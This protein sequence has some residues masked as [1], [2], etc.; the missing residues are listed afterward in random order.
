MTAEPVTRALPVVRRTA[1]V[2]E[3]QPAV[4]AVPVAAVVVRRPAPLL[5]TSLLLLG[6]L[7]LGF[8]LHLAVVGAVVHA[9]AQGLGY[10]ELREDLA[11]ATAPVGPTEPGRPVALLEVPG[12]SLREVVREGTTA[13]VLQSGPGHRRDSVLPGQ[14]GTSVLFGR[15]AAFG[16]PFRGLAD[17]RPGQQVAV[18][19]G[20]GRAVFEVTG[21]RRAGDP[22][23][24]PLAAGEGRLTLVTADGTPFAP[25]GVLRVD[26][27]LIGTAF[28]GA[29]PA[30]ALEE[31]ERALQGDPGAL[32]PLLLL[33]QGLLLAACGVAWARTRWGARQAWVA[34]VPVLLALGLGTAHAASALLPN[35]L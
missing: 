13:T 16:A 5:A 27:R 31:R 26:A 33:A 11:N 9:R 20:L 21:L 4:P 19:S 29:A 18:T 35:L 7:L 14:A 22:A 6:V 8:V 32:V 15:Q 30:V 10:A 17:L 2:R 3:E 28:P 1:V 23:P 25:S 24:A 34:G 12:T